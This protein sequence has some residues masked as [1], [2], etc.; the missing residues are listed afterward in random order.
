LNVGALLRVWNRGLWNHRCVLGIGEDGL[1]VPVPVARS[2]LP[3]FRLARGK[4]GASTTSGVDVDV[5]GC[6]RLRDLRVEG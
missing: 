3:P 4:G 5:D 6:S 2:F 1:Q